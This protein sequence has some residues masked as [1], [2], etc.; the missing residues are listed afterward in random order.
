MKLK[1]YIA[2]SLCAFALAGCSDDDRKIGVT[3]DGDAIEIGA[4]GGTRNIKVTAD[5]AWI[6]TTND[7]WITISPANG[8]GSAQCRIIIDSALRNEP[9]QGIVRIQNQND[10]EE[11]RDITVS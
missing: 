11:R 5:D 4:E 9:R 6:A 2:V 8:R 3:V 7:P 1:S 10:W